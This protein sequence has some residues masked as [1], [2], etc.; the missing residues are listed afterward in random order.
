MLVGIERVCSPT[1]WYDATNIVYAVY[2]STFTDTNTSKT[3]DYYIPV[4]VE[5]I[6][7]D[8]DGLYSGTTY[9]YGKYYSYNDEDTAHKS[10]DEVYKVFE[11]DKKDKYTI[12]EIK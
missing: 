8:D 5:D 9:Y 1:A 12:T 6:I 3:Y 2:K 11:N 4:Y 7:V 10:A